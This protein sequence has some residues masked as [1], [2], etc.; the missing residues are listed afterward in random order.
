MHNFASTN[1][2]YISYYV[3]VTTQNQ[4][5][6]SIKTCNERSNFLYKM[7]C[8]MT[9][10]SL[11]IIDFNVVVFQQLS[12]VLHFYVRLSAIRLSFIREKVG[13]FGAK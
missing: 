6:M 3:R 7:R 5:E 1:S 9:E 4:N 12:H 10:F 11:R 2:S 13:L 8:I